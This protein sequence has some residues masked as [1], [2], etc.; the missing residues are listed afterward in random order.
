M[1]W[2]RWAKRGHN[3]HDLVLADIN[4]PRMDEIIQ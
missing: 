4:M 3:S 2:I 1:V